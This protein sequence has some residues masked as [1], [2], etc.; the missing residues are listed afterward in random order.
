MTRNRAAS[1]PSSPACRDELE[2]SRDGKWV[3][4]VSVPEGSL[5]KAAAD[6]SQHLPLTSSPLTPNMPHWSPD[7]SQIAFTGETP[8]KPPRIYVVSS[9]GG[10]VRQVTNG[11]SGKYGDDDPS[12]SPD[13]ASLAF[14][15]PD[16]DRPARTPFWWS[17]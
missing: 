7:G 9:D 10:P 13:G 11:E 5:V 14:G 17:I 6:G 15:G 1:F 16:E 4:Y 8:G 12:W 3:V 2:Y